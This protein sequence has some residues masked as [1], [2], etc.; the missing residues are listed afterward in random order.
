[1]YRPVLIS[2]AGLALAGCATVTRGTSSQIQIV[3][4]PSGATARTS[5][6]HQCVT[7]CTLQ[8]GRKDE[9]AVVF[10]LPGHED[11]TVNVRTQL[12][13]AG[14]A[15]FAGN[16]VLGGVVGMGVDAATGATLEHLPNP[17]SVVLRPIP[18]PAPA[19]SA[20]RP[21][22]SRPVAGAVADLPRAV[23]IVP[24]RGRR[25][26]FPPKAVSPEHA[27]LDMPPPVCYIAL[28]RPD[29]SP[30]VAFSMGA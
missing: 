22:G 2:L 29:P 1:M 19:R 6:G 16:V 23:M 14:A 5:L 24:A 13:G 8:V 18:K 10:T 4:E 7:P 17:V 27:V 21:R 25:A 3:S 26:F 15:G 30:G 12:A 28:A 11:Q 20:P 9:F